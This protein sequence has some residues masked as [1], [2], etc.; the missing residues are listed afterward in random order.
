[1]EFD[2]G[3][4]DMVRAIS[5]VMTMLIVAIDPD[6]HF[7]ATED[8]IYDALSEERDITDDDVETLGTHIRLT[9]LM[10][11]GIQ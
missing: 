6:I 4:A 8:L 2:I 11:K 7:N 5:N 3:D 1:M 10:P 9:K